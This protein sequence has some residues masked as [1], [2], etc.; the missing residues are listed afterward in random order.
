MS[1]DEARKEFPR[2]LS[3]SKITQKFIGLVFLKRF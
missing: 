1:E 2:F 3:D